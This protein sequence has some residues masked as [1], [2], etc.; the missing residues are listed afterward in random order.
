M[1]EKVSVGGGVGVQVVSK[2][3]HGDRS[4]SMDGREGR[5]WDERIRVNLAGVWEQEFCLQVGGQLA[6]V[7]LC[8]EPDVCCSWVPGESRY[9]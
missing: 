9:V 5:R 7:L 4:E 3:V 2:E 6:V 1:F 8:R